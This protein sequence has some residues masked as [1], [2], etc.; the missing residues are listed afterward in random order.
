MRCFFVPVKQ[1]KGGS[2]LSISQ[3]FLTSGQTIRRLLRLSGLGKDDHIVEI[4]AGKGH[5]TREL[6]KIGRFVSAYEPDGKLYK[7]LTEKL[8]GADNLALIKRDFLKTALPSGEYKV[9]SNIPFSITSP[10]I[11]KLTAS[12]NPPG[13]AWL[14]MEKGAAKRFCGT[15]RDTLASMLLKPFFDVKILYHFSRRDFHPMPGVDAVLLRMSKKK[16][17]DVPA[18]QRKAFIRFMEQSVR[19]GNRTTLTNKQITA[20][21]K[22]AGLPRVPESGNM[23]YVQ[24]LCLFRC[25]RELY[26][27][28]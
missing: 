28:R 24:W 18:V 17:P 1:N 20:A 27:G 15:P 14:V 19:Y 22:A 13:E 25:F 11:R 23:L 2:P 21:L 26:N 4:G 3:N 8:G 9:F 10:I 16:E 7:Q 12:N 6:I 5:I